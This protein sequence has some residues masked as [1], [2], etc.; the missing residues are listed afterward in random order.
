MG[1]VKQPVCVL[2]RIKGDSL[3]GEHCIYPLKNSH[4]FTAYAMAYWL[5]DKRD[6]GLYDILRVIY[7]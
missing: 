1:C 2:G 5:L 7:V 6:D 3:V 4:K